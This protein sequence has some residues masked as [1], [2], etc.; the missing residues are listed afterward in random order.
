MWQADVACRPSP[1]H[2]HCH[3][4]DAGHR[5]CRRRR[6]SRWSVF[7]PDLLSGSVLAVATAALLRRPIKVPA[8]LAR[9]CF[10]VDRHPARRRGDAADTVKSFATWPASIAHGHGR[11]LRHD[12]G[13]RDLSARVVHR[14]D[15]LSALMGASPGSMTQVI[16][17]STELGADF[18]RHRDRADLAGPAPDHR[19]TGRAWRC[20]G[21]WRRRYRLY[22]ARPGGSSV[23]EMAI[24]RC[25]VDAPPLSR[26]GG[27][28]FPP[29]C[30]SA[31]WP[32]RAC[33]TAPASSTRC[34]HGGSASAAILCSARSSARASPTRLRA[35]WLG[36]LGA[37]FGSFAVSM[38][39][40]RTLFAL[41][42]THFFPFP[43]ANVVV[44]FSPGAQDT[45]MVL[46]LALHLDPVY[47]G[48]HH[49]ARLSWSLSRLPS[50]RAAD[51][52]GCA[53]RPNSYTPPRARAP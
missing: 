17:L 35:C 52:K 42:V 2:S 26:C 34:C 12:A 29:D 3:R 27:C 38:A 11:R 19:H 15:R 39:W 32:D 10:V 44:A 22:A 33:C 23:P 46:A 49:V 25:G 45:M 1:A 47:V 7:P 43:I 13:D 30:C 48:A 50:S 9:I 31:P 28:G 16:A 20:S 4:R 21:W 36:Y 6:R 41:I 8:P 51:R 24:C 5:A 40:S 14:W 18:A 53:A 37:A